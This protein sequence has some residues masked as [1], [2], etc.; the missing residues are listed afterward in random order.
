VKLG[1]LILLVLVLA[2][3]N[4]VTKILGGKLEDVLILCSGA[5]NF[6]AVLDVSMEPALLSQARRTKAFLMVQ[7]VLISYIIGMDLNNFVGQDR[8][9]VRVAISSLLFLV[10]FIVLVVHSSMSKTAQVS[11]LIFSFAVCMAIHT[12]A[13]LAS[14][15]F[16]PWLYR[17]ASWV[18]PIINRP[19]DFLVHRGHAYLHLLLIPALYL[20]TDL[21]LRNENT[22]PS[23]KASLPLDWEIL[24]VG[25]ACA[26]AGYGYADADPRFE[27]GAPE[28]SGRPSIPTRLSMQ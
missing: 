12:N 22:V 26:L 16:K 21:G 14:H 1:I 18:G 5:S 6:V 27:A 15:L 7:L 4:W 23:A 24:S 11:W 9:F 8:D 17:L 3:S 20:V 19:A 2:A 10:T 25:I 13:E 28:I